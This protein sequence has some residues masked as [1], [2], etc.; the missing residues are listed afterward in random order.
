MGQIFLPFEDWVIVYACIYH[1]L[2]IHS[3]ISGHLDYFYLWAT[4]NSL[5]VYKYP[6]ANLFCSMYLEVELLGNMVIVFRKKISRDH[7][8][9]FCRGRTILDSH[10]QCIRIPV[11]LYP[12]QYLLFSGFLLK[13]IVTLLMCVRWYLIIL[14][15]ISLMISDAKH[16]FMCFLTIS[17]SSLEELKFFAH[18]L[19]W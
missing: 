19:I 18:V 8:I 7:Q 17:L 14:I 1:I 5:K 2:L 6:S 3:F 9:A 16:L 4:M 13:F 11:S 12:C 15:C 10:Q